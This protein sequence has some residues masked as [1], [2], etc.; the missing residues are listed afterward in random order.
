MIDFFGSGYDAAEQL[1]LIPDLASIHYPIERFAFVDAQ[2]KERFSLRYSRLR[3]RLFND[4]HF[5]FMRGDLERVLYHRFGTHQD[6]RFGTTVSSFLQ[7]GRSVRVALSDGTSQTVDLLVG[8]DGVHSHIRQL[9]FGDERQFARMPGYCMA[10]F[11]VDEPLPSL[12]AR[13]AFVTLTLPNRQVTVYPI[14]G[15]RTATFF[16]H[17][18]RRDVAGLSLALAYQELEHVYGDLNWLVPELLVHCRTARAVYL[19]MIEQ[20]EMPRW[21]TGRVVLLGDACQC[22]SPLAGQGASMAVAGADA[23]AGA[24]DEHPDPEDA[25]T[26]YEQRLKPAIERQQKAG[27]RIAKWFVPDD[28]LHLIVRDTVMRVSTWPLVA[29]VIR[30]RMSAASIFRS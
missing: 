26:Q 10:A 23:L 19:D 29:P 15:N 14:R 5:N 4:R 24:L 25:L 11:I 7:D 21:A 18:A 16:L 13:D 12:D 9:A 6:V 8:A 3:T 17:K 27:R 30:R 28:E 2:G 22:V 1:G 20:I